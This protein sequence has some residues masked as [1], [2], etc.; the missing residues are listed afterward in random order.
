M[1]DAYT[2]IVFQRHSLQLRA[3]MIDNRP[4]FI[5]YDFAR[6]IAAPRALL[7]ARRMPAHQRR[8]VLLQGADPAIGAHGAPYGGARAGGG[9]FPGFHPGYTL[10]PVGA[11]PFGLGGCPVGCAVRTNG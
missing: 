10:D 11:N 4:W 7:L 9:T 5:A 8:T 6:L 2:P 3:V 1:H